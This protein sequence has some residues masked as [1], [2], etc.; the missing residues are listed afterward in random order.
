MTLPAA[1][2]VVLLL[3]AAYNVVENPDWH[4]WIEANCGWFCR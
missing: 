4:A 3:V 1:V 2:L